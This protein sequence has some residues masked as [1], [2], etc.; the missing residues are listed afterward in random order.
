M[1]CIEISELNGAVG[2]QDY[3]EQSRIAEQW[4]LDAVSRLIHRPIL[5]TP[6]RGRHA[7][8]FTT[9]QGILGDVKIWS[10][11]NITVEITQTR[12]GV[13]MPGW[14]MEYQQLN[15]FGGLLAINYWLSTYHNQG[16]FKIR[17]IPWN[18]LC[19]AVNTA[20][21]RNNRFGSY[22][23]VDPT[24]ITHVWLGDFM[25]VHSKH[26]KPHMAF[27]AGR[28]FANKNLHIP[29]LYEWF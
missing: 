6:G 27:D 24:H 8:D 12:Q 16:V 15:N 20:Q 29:D 26:G 23:H 21:V 1:P 7:C 17:W 22:C 14:Y 4:V 25:S 11:S 5:S 19:G 28:I 3:F 10:G 2:N 18:S 13:D 9:Q